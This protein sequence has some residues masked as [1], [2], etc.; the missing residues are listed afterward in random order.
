MPSKSAK[1]AKLMAAVANN[2]KFAKKV[3]IPTSVGQEFANADKR[4]KDMPSYFNS[5]KAKPGKVVKKYARGR[6]VRAHDKKELRDL[7]DEDFRI[8][9][10]SGSNTD[11]ER[12]RIDRERSYLK[13]QEGSYSAGGGVGSASSRG[14]GIAQQGHTRGRIV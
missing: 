14:D 11:A 8:R 7:H 1:Q 2:P 4:N 6:D 3:G 13:R 12:R 9:N 5:S 10:R